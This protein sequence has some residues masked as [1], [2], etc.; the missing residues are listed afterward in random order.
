MNTLARQDRL[1]QV[2]DRYLW[3]RNGVLHPVRIV[4]LLP[5]TPPEPSLPEA[6][7]TDASRVL[8]QVTGGVHAGVYALAETRH[9]RETEKK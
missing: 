3:E 4:S 5:L 1:M 6:G 7:P 8:V 9:L 2:G